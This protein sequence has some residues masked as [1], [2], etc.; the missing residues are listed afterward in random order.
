MLYNALL[1][2]HLLAVVV[3]VGGMALMHFVVRPA[4]AAALEPPQRLPLMTQILQGFFRWVTAAVLLILATGI[5]MMRWLESGG[6]TPPVYLHLMMGI[7]LVM[8]LV[9]AWIR[10]REF[11]LLQ[12]AVAISTWPVAGAALLRIRR[13]VSVNL[14]LGVLT[15]VVAILGRTLA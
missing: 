1:C 12:K 11:P 9:F 13:L 14:A 6:A 8:A 7:G 4:V 3:W 15:I 5:A 10:L 2:L